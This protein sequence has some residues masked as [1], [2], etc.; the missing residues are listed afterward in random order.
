MTEVHAG[1]NERFDEF[2]LRLSHDETNLPISNLR[3]AIEG[4]GTAIGPERVTVFQS[5]IGN[6]KPQIS[7]FSPARQP[8]AKEPSIAMG[9]MV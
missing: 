4:Q 6:R 1:I 2:C 7:L 9:L 5:Q 8:A 3:F